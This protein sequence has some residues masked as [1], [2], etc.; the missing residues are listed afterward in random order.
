M[1]E[2]PTI[3]PNIFGSILLDM[4]IMLLRAGASGRRIR[5]TESRMALAYQYAHYLDLGPKSISVTLL[6]R[7]GDAVFN[8]TRSA[9]SYGVDFKIISAIH[10]LTEAV[11]L[12]PLDIEELKKKLLRLQKLPGYP[13]I[14]VLFA[15]SLGGAAF[16]YTF[17]G[18]FSAMCVT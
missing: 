15:V 10:R 13:R 9:L 16:C 5:N 8:G 12:Y 18:R 17:G 14:L 7:Q 4:A 3:Q 6:N 1:Q 2:A 11:Q